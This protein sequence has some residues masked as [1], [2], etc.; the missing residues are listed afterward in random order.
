M[1]PTGRRSSAA[2]K[3]PPRVCVP[4]GL[5]LMAGR[6]RK[7]QHAVRSAAAADVSGTFRRGCRMPL[8][9]G[10]VRS[11]RARGRP[12]PAGTA[13]RSARPPATAARPVAR[14][15]GGSVE[16]TLCVVLGV[17]Q[18]AGHQGG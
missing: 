4:A 3:E 5:T 8:A 9:L 2:L 13:F 11:T 18:P 15:A 16:S 12:R 14:E 10:E 1:Y 7:T 6:P 17:V